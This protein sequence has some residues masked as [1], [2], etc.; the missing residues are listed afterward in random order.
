MATISVKVCD[1][2]KS[3]ER[4]A[5]RWTVQGPDGARVVVDLCEEHDSSLRDFMHEHRSTLRKPVRR[6]TKR[7]HNREVTTIEEIEKMKKG[8]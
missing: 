4:E 1:V 2:C 6:A 5:Q 8:K 7:T 3:V